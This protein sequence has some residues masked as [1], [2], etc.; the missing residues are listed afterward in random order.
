MIELGE[1]RGSIAFYL[2]FKEPTTRLIFYPFPFYDSSVLVRNFIMLN[3]I[4]IE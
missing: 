2:L 1:K 4:M 3:L